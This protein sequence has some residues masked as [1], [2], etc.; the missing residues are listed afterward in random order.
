MIAETRFLRVCGESETGFLPKSGVG[1]P[2]LSQ[3]PGF[4]DFGAICVESETGFLPKSG[5]GIPR[6]SQKP[7]FQDCRR[8]PVS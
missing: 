7:G 2:R 5:V 3:K 8:N 1:I 4:L 6:L